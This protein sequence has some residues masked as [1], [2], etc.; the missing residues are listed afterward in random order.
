MKISKKVGRPVMWIAMEDLLS[1]ITENIS[2][3]VYGNYL[4][5][6]EAVIKENINWRTN[7]DVLVRN[8]YLTEI[9]NI[10]GSYILVD[11]N[12]KTIE[13]YFL[14]VERIIVKTAKVI[15]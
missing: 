14:P 9:K 8:K 5:N 12:F 1:Q 6:V 3:V 7:I 15:K 2:P 10:Y 11:D 13:K 4:E